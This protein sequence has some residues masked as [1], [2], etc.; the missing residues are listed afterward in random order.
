M[1]KP[2]LVLISFVLCLLC[3]SLPVQV[4]AAPVPGVYINEIKL[5]GTVSGQPT[6]FIELIN[7]KNTAVDLTGWS[8]EYAKEGFDGTSCDA[9]S[10]E[11]VDAD[12]DNTVTLLSST[13]PASTE[14]SYGLLLLELSLTDG[15]A[16]SIQL[17]D[18]QNARQD[19]VGWGEVAPC[20]SGD[21]ADVPQNGKSIERYLDCEGLVVQSNNNID[22]FLEGNPPSP[23]SVTSSF[24]PECTLPEEPTPNETTDYLPVY[25]NELMPNPAS[26]LSD[27]DAEFIELY[28]PNSIA[29]NLKD[30]TLQT[31]TNFQ[32]E[33]K[34]PGFNIEAKGYIVLYSSETNLVL[35]NTTSN[36]RIIDPSG[37]S[38]NEATAYEDVGENEAWA[39]HDGEWW[40]TETPTPGEENFIYLEV[41]TTSEGKG[42]GLEPCPTGKFRNPETNRCKNIESVSGLTPCKAGRVRNPDTNRCRSVAVG[43]TSLTPCKPGQTRNPATNR[44]RAVAGASTSLVPCKPGYERSIE[45]NRCRK[46]LGEAAGGL[47]NPAVAQTKISYP[48]IILIS[49]LAV[50]YG[51]YEYRQ[52]ITEYIKG[53]SKSISGN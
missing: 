43:A 6:Q 1:I 10:W 32:Y 41:A 51:V 21:A 30:W 48:A 2:F 9:I 26:P 34:M 14:Q 37:G 27:E 31:G 5:G 42:G 19:L 28:N 20:A 13:L 12:N 3:S 44:C 25:L 15:K 29:V 40:L 18:N 7:T 4:T 39:K 8:L 36:A 45:T 17:V 49:I 23:G 53:L 35:S 46:A 11:S 33:Y 22:D 52:E 38:I 47:T 16:G 50:G 24:L